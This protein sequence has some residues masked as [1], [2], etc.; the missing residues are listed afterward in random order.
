M[1]TCKQQALMKEEPITAIPSAPPGK[2]LARRK[3]YMITC[4]NIQF[5][6]SGHC[7]T[8]YLNQAHHWAV[9]NSNRRRLEFLP[10]CWQNNPHKKQHQYSSARACFSEPFLKSYGP[11]I[12]YSHQLHSR[13]LRTDQKACNFCLRK[14]GLSSLREE[15]QMPSKLAGLFITIS[16]SEKLEK[17][18]KIWFIGM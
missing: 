16:K 9:M 17:S 8:Q 5:K 2:C 6:A 18:F 11:S 14:T 7:I 1:V 13:V 12:I 15:A 3:G 4:L 10:K